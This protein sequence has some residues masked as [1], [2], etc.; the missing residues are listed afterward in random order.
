M[1]RRFNRM[2]AVGAIA[3]LAATACASRPAPTIPIT[4]YAASSLVKSFTAIGKNFE[5][6]NPRYSVMF[7]FASS[8]ELSSELA[9]GADA[10]VFASG[11]RANMTAV[12]DA[13]GVSGTPVPFAANRLVVV[14]PAGNPRQLTSF[15]DL[16]QSGLRVSVC[17][18]QGTSCGSATQLVEQRTGVQL[19][20]TNS[21]PTPSHVLQDVTSGKA[22]AGVVFMTD[23][24]AAGDNVTSFPLPEDADA[25]T[26]WITVV[27]GTDQDRGAALFVQEVTGANGRQILADNGFSP[28]PKNPAG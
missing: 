25:V 9:D 17:V 14:T 13:G 23:A 11:D 12:A 19:R 18:A 3:L 6:S 15:P 27:K 28:P 26:S 7:I 21:E 20:P 8:P 5:A 4:V 22:D 10:D 2:M 16:A 1:D 24:L